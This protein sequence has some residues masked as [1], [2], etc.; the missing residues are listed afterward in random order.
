MA[1]TCLVITRQWSTE[2]LRWESLRYKDQTYVDARGTDNN[3]VSKVE[4]RG[5][6]IFGCPH[7]SQKGAFTLRQDNGVC[8][9]DKAS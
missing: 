4:V 1:I 9:D 3:K 6:T 8:F 2:A 7:L 5:N